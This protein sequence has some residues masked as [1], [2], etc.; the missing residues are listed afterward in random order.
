MDSEADRLAMIQ[1][2]GG[3]SVRTERG[4]AT[5]IFDNGHVGL[6]TESGFE[7]TDRSPQLTLSTA[8]ADRLGLVRGVVV[9]V[10]ESCKE[11][12]RYTVRDPQPDGTGMSVILLD[13]P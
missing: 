2:L 11:A 1:S 3:L 8:E 13:A 6:P 4:T 12:A 9:E 7:L 10:L 5:A